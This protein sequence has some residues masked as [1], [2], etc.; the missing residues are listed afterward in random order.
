MN[1][2]TSSLASIYP[3]PGLRAALVRRFATDFL[4]ADLASNPW[5]LLRDHGSD[6]ARASQRLH[7][8]WRVFEVASG[9]HPCVSS[10]QPS[11]L[12]P[13]VELA[14]LQAEWLHA[15]GLPGMLMRFPEATG[16]AAPVLAA[17][18]SVVTLEELRRASDAAGLVRLFVLHRGTGRAA[19]GLEGELREHTLGVAGM[20]LSA[21]PVLSAC[22]LD[23]GVLC[24]VVDRL[25]RVVSGHARRLEGAARLMA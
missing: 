4:P 23:A 20:P 13:C 1:G 19:D 15:A 24:E 7:G 18:V 16:P 12:P 21:A 11:P 10:A 25:V 9:L 22:P 2:R 3:S 17:A 8:R 6:D 14:D 5:S